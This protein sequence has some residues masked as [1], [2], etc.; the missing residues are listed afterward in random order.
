MQEFYHAEYKIYRENGDFELQNPR[1]SGLAVVIFFVSL[2][3]VLM[4]NFIQELLNAHNVPD[5]V[6]DYVLSDSPT[7]S[8]KMNK[9]FPAL[10]GLSWKKAVKKINEHGE[11]DYEELDRFVERIVKARNE[12]LHSGVKYAIHEDMPQACLENIW[13]LLNLYVALHNTYVFP[14]YQRRKESGR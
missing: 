11:I 5:N 9:L 4:V 6:Y 7:H 3:E 2:R 1:N 10:A 14:V 13:S 8:H 12:F